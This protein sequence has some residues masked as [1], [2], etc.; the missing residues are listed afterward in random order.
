MDYSE[1]MPK[2][3]SLEGALRLVEQGALVDW[4][5]PLEGSA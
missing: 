5:L 1:L 3:R 4:R 2:E